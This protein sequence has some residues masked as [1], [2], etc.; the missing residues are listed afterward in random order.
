PA[1]SGDTGVVMNLGSM[2][3]EPSAA[4]TPLANNSNS[5]VNSNVTSSS[6]GTPSGASS[7]TF[8]GTW[9]LFKFFDAGSPKKQAGGEYLLIY[10]LGGKI[11][12]ATVKP[13]GDVDLFD[14]SVFTSV[15]TP[16][17]FLK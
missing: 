1:T 12:T 7:L 2:A 9:G 5:N 3:T 15:K 14:R 6:S 16:Q 17:T 13:T 4:A 10:K 8:P 11:V